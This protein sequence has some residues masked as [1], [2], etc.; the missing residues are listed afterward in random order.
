MDAV[1]NFL[2]AVQQRAL[3]SLSLIVVCLFMHGAAAAS[4]GEER[5]L[6]LAPASSHSDGQRAP[7]SVCESVCQPIPCDGLHQQED[8][9]RTVDRRNSKPLSS[10]SVPTLTHE[11]PTCTA[12][13]H[14]RREPPGAISI[15]LQIL[16]CTWLN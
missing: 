3:A 7:D 8:S 16:F 11:T 15:P 12:S 5:A 13:P 4:Q 6:A 1:S 10:H 14:G 9:G 2:K